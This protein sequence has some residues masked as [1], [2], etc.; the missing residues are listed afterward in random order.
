LDILEEGIQI[1]RSLLTQ[2]STTFAGRHFQVEEAFCFPRPVQERPRLWIGGG[3]E[4]RTLRIAARHADGWNAVYISP[5]QYRHKLQVLERWC[6][7]EGRDPAEITRS[8]NVGFY[9]GADDAD[10][11]RLRGR[12]GEAWEERADQRSGGMLF[13]TTAEAIDRIGAYADAG[14]QGLNIALRAPFN[15]DALQAFAEEVLPAFA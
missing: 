9:M 3:G 13:G 15:W 8:V 10:A 2:E 12:F 4:R 1:I 5:E 14:A 6:D 11:Q 7:R